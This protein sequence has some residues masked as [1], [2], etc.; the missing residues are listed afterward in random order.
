MSSAIRVGS[1]RYGL[2]VIG[3]AIPVPYPGRHDR[4]AVA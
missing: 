4:K 3:I 2:A 1:V